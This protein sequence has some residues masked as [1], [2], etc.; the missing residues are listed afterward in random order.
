MYY[1]V[2]FKI[3]IKLNHRNAWKFAIIICAL[4]SWKVSFSFSFFYRFHVNIVV[5]IY[6]L[7]INSIQ[8]FCLAKQKMMD[9]PGSEWTAVTW[10]ADAVY[11]Q[12]SGCPGG[13]GRGE[14]G[15]RAQSTWALCRRTP[16]TVW[17]FAWPFGPWSARPS[18][19]AASAAGRSYTGR[20]VSARRGRPPR[21]GRTRTAWC[22]DRSCTT[23]TRRRRTT[24][25]RRR[26]ARTSATSGPA[27]PGSAPGRASAGSPAHSPS[28]ADTVFF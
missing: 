8:Y 15:G 4:Y 1:N 19:G 25:R 24:V 20:R 17:A 2:I 16:R 13:R 21:L 3:L 7:K 14:N 27:G 26:S 6:F 12:V 11:V 23:G 9:V 10:G 5:D 22:W 28:S 18:A